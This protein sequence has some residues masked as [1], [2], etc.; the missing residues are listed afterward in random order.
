MLFGLV[1]LVSPAIAGIFGQPELIYLLPVAGVM[2]IFSGL[3][4]V[5]AAILQRD[6]LFK[7]LAVRQV[8]GTVAGSSIALLLAFGGAGVWALVLQPVVTAFASTVVLWAAA[9]WRPR[10]QY[11]FASLRSNWRFSAQVVLLELLNALQSN[12]DK[13]I[14]GVFFSPTQL[15]FYFLGQRI[16]TVLIE[17]FASVLARV[18]LPALSRVQGDQR[19]FL[20]YFYTFTFASSA[21]AFPVFA[22]V[23]VFG[24]PLTSFLFGAEWAEVVPLMWL[25][26]PSAAL[27]SVTFFDKSALL[28][29]GRGAVSLGIATGQFAFGTVLLLAA[30]PFG[31]YVVAAGRSLRQLLYWPVR[32]AALNK[33]AGV[34]PLAYLRRFLTPT[35]GSGLIIIGGLILNGTPWAD[36]PTPIISFVVPASITLLGIYA[37]FICWVERRE[38]RRILAVLR[39]RDEE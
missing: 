14:V 12:I 13:F 19:R 4:S 7:P 11:S 9:R 39:T 15:G 20:D 32:I 35:V 6:L 3:S 8:I 28:A 37:L 38:V 22:L 25:L 34:R 33:Y 17:V 24:Y 18:S 21:V 30:V 2:L 10:L 16:L 27:A 26:M 29:K 5:P 31:L 36:A 1:W 23:A